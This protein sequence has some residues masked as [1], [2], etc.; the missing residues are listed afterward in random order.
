MQAEYVK[1]HIFQVLGM[2]HTALLPDWSDNSLV[3]EGRRATKSYYLDEEN[4]EDYG[5]AIS[6]IALYPAGALGLTLFFSYVKLMPYELT[7]TS[8]V[9]IALISVACSIPII[10]N[11]VGQ[12]IARGKGENVPRDLA[13]SIFASLGV[14]AA[15]F[16]DLYKFWI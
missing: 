4:S 12:I 11:L 5:L 2:D 8:K 10:S 3:Q 1:E 16:F 6:H 7:G 9:R 14:V 13:W 15:F